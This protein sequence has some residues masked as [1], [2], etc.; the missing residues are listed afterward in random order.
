MPC[1]KES[2]YLGVRI[3]T[4]KVRTQAFARTDIKRHLKHFKYKLRSCNVDVKEQL[5]QSYGR[6]I[7]TYIGTP[8]L[9]AKIFTSKQITQ[10]EASLYREAHSL[11]N[12]ISN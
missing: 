9:G 5:L 7:M 6:S 1:K 11:P 2:K 8:L 12:S 10:L 4:D 3:S